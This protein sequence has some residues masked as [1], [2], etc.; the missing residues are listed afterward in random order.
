MIGFSY[1]A[2]CLLFS[3]L[4][5]F[6]IVHI[7]HRRKVRIRCISSVMSFLL[8]RWWELQQN[9]LFIIMQAVCNWRLKDGTE[10]QVFV[11][12]VKKQV[13]GV[14]VIRREEVNF[15]FLDTHKHAILLWSWPWPKPLIYEIHLK[16]LK[17]YLH[18]KSGLSR[19]RLSKVSALQTD[20]H[21]DRCNQMH[22]LSAFIVVIIII[23]WSPRTSSV[24]RHSLLHFLLSHMAVHHLHHL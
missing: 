12:E 18:T 24:V 10:L 11:A 15:L 17:L 3:S 2:V 22:Y 9:V 23:H 7:W 20:R 14:A 19:S 4:F 21:T 13:V 5:L 16:I 8:L 6:R 1:V